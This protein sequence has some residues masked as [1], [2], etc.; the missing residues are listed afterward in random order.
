MPKG[1]NQ[2]NPVFFGT[3]DA[4]SASDPISPATYWHEIRKDEHSIKDI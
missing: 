1:S 3:S 4:I 2:W